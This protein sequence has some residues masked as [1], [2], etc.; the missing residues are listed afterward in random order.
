MTFADD[1]TSMLRELTVLPA[2]SGSEDA[3]SRYFAD[4]LAHDV[5]NVSIDLL[6]NVTARIGTGQPPRIAVLAH[7]DTVGFQVKSVSADGMV[8]VVS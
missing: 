7:M 1:F 2:I 3:M 4:Q 5:E 8:R 6:G